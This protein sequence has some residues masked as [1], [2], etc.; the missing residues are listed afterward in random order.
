[1]LALG[2]F[3]NANAAIISG[4]H[5]ANN[6]PV[7]L[8]GLQ[9]LSLDITANLSYTDL[10]NT[11]VDISGT[12][13]DRLSKDVFKG[14]PGQD[15][16]LG[17]RL[18]KVE[19]VRALLSSLFS[20][21]LLKDRITTGATPEPL[22]NATAAQWFLTHFGRLGSSS[23]PTFFKYGERGA[24]GSVTTLCHEGIFNNGGT[25]EYQAL[26]RDDQ[27]NSKTADSGSFL[28]R[29]IPV[30]APPTPTIEASEPST[31]LLSVL[32]LLGLIGRARLANH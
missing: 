28:V 22:A 31:V 9:W 13:T 19:E 17:W 32:M 8:S 21:L 30:V 6:Q 15:I 7:N 20:P 12:P 10:F 11:P 1:M 5:R 24:C 23:Q 14:I 29:T 2:L 27:L 3:S 16:G 18:A 4:E 25:T 26:N